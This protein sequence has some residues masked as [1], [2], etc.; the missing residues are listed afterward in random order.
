VNIL[1]KVSHPRVSTE[2]NTCDLHAFSLS[3]QRGGMTSYTTEGLVVAEPGEG[4]PRWIGASRITTKV[5]GGQTHGGF[6]LIVSEVTRDT[7][8]PLHI[9]HTADESMW[10][11]PGRD[12]GVLHRGRA[13]RDVGDPAPAGPGAAAAGGGEVPV[14]VRRAAAVARLTS[15]PT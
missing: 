7:S 3:G 13:G 10:V 15:G 1:N 6:G 4:E 5:T 11:V 2:K 12:R 8:S 14:R 9:H